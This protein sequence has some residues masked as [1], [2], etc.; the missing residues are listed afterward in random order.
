MD[1][2]AELILTKNKC[3]NR[4]MEVKPS[5]LLENYDRLTDQPGYREVSLPIRTKKSQE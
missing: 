5:A 1:K 4:S 3:S 2:E